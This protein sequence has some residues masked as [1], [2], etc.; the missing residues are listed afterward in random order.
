MSKEV[1]KGK[2]MQFMLIMERYLS[3]SFFYLE[4]FSFLFT[5]ELNSLI[6]HILNSRPLLKLVL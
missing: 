5:T 6:K 2:C 3:L 4:A 1:C